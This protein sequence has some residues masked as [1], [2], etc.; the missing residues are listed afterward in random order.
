MSNPDLHMGALLEEPLAS[1]ARHA[2]SSTSLSLGQ[3]CLLCAPLLMF[4]LLERRR[5]HGGVR[6]QSA[7]MHLL[8]P[9]CEVQAHVQQVRVPALQEVC[10]G[11]QVPA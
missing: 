8:E 9:L 10:P 6:G 11:R 1:R 4:L 7:L 2:W 5:L 3:P